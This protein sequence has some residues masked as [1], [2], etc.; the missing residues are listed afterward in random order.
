M[1]YSG[2]KNYRKNVILSNNMEINNNNNRSTVN[3]NASIFS[4]DQ[5][6]KLLEEMDIT[7]DEPNKTEPKQ[8][9][10]LSNEKN[11]KPIIKDPTDISGILSSNLAEPLDGQP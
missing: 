11:P 7:I 5:V 3:N 4:K 9:R 8:Q 10:P 2:A 1:K 6:E